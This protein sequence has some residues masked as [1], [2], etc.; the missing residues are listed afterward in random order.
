VF[1][2]IIKDIL[3]QQKNKNEKIKNKT[4]RKK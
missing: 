1:L 4:R 2:D 3:L